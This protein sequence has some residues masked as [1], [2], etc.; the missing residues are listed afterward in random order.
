MNGSAAPSR[1]SETILLVA[2]LAVAAAIRLTL[3]FTT[4]GWF[5]EIYIVR[6]AA[7]PLAEAL[8]LT[9][10]D[11]SPPFQFLLRC[12]W[13]DLAG[14]SVVGHKIFSVLFALASMVLSFALARRALG[15]RAAF[16]ML[17]LLTVSAL[18]VQ[19]S[20]EIEEYSIEWTLVAALL[21]T[22]WRWIEAGGRRD[23]IAY[24]LCG[25]IAEINH[26]ESI[27]VIAIL[28]VS[29][30]LV[31]ARTPKRA[32]AWLGLNAIALLLFLPFVPT[33][34]TQLAR[35]SGGRFFGFPSLHALAGLWRAMGD[36]SRF[37]LYPML[38]LSVVPFLRKETRRFALFLAPLL[39]FAP[40]ATKF[41][42]V[43]LPREV[44]FILPPWLMLVGA[45]IA[46]LRPAAVQAAVLAVLL[47]LGVRTLRPL[48]RYDEILNT[49]DAERALAPHVP[50]GG[51][52]LHAET[53]SLLYFVEYHPEFENRLL[54]PAGTHVPFFEG[55]LIVPESLYIDYAAWRAAREA[56]RP[57]W[58]V[59]D[60]RAL[61]TRGQVWRAGEAPAESMAVYGDTLARAGRV[62]VWE[63]RAPR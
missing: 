59:R 48:P 61:A 22:G 14:S 8:R 49:R 13:N 11:I 54:L 21:L 30:A 37:A 58:G 57:W 42:V 28:A 34:L 18:H 33:M 52:V 63:S 4:P 12:P 47:A 45:G 25:A 9:A 35:E 23:A 2:I 16:F 26:Y 29:G 53:H 20:P 7:R 38:A 32:G 41:W 15:K 43:I 19:F 46:S 31:L 3:A 6:V 39:L 17:A 5:A 36:H 55:G 24:V 56:G 60:D 40:F 1:K 44:I 51:L 10:A 50:R 62:T 27:P